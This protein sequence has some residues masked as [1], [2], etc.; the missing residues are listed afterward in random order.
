MYLFHDR[1]D[2]VI[3]VGKA[4]SLRE[5]V[6]SYF[7]SPAGLTA[8]TLHMVGEARRIETIVTPTEIEALILEQN[9][10]KTHRPKY[11]VKLKDDKQYPYLK[12]TAEPFPRLLTTRGVRKD[13][14]KYFG[15]YPSEGALR[16]TLRLLRRLIPM[17]TCSQQ[18]FA[19]VKRP[20]LLYDIHRCPGPCQPGL[21][22]EDAYAERVRAAEQFL[23]G[24]HEAVRRSIEAEMLAAA[25]DLRFEEA[26]RLRD[27]LRA[28]ERVTQRQ[29]VV[30]PRGGDVDV[31]AVAEVEGQWA[32]QFF[33]VRD[34]KLVGREGI[35]FE[36]GAEPDPAH[37]LGRIL[38]AHYTAATFV[39]PMVLLPEDPPQ[40]EL[41]T[42]WLA[43]RRGRAVRILV[44]RRGQRRQLVEM[45]LENAREAARDAAQARAR[46]AQA[47][48]GRD[49][50]VARL[51]LVARPERIE[52][53]DISTLQGT[54]TVAAMACFIHG[55][56]A[57]SAYRR[58]RIQ[59]LQGQDDFRALAEAVRRRLMRSAPAARDPWPLPDLI[60]IDGG[61]GQLHAVLPVLVEAGREA[62]PVFALAKQQEELF[63]P[64]RPD[65]IRLPI[66][67]PGLTMLRALRDEAHRFG[68]GYHRSLRGRAA[69][70]SLLD[71]IPG[72]GASRRQRLMA[73]FGSLDALARAPLEEIR[74]AG[75][76]AGLARTIREALAAGAS[77]TPQETQHTEQGDKVGHIHGN[78]GRV[79]T[80]TAGGL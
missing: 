18:K 4:R 70:R 46:Q 53:F 69:L 15:P 76:P 54:N 30:S 59:S 21:I 74:A 80:G 12:I 51:N 32:G 39:P 7:Q 9:L 22:G 29:A 36:P 72:I 79:G 37:V 24:H 3:Y 57:P 77:A 62:I 61:K 16:E 41:L 13:G 20:C 25:E 27:R 50:L 75:V 33:Q 68:V 1:S 65:P 63:A 23:E 5:R 58:F 44:P 38:E 47:P 6:R 34:G 26:A 49:D 19:T 10:I 8:K 31:V 45:A 78:P 40:R 60:L 55:R 2:R 56:R 35:E 11:N 73:A 42:Q 71:D 48:D 66:D 14:A 43:A 52:C 28:I 17:R 67:S 64:D